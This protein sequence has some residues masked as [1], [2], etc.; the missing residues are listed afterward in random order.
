M[1][2]ELATWD[3]ERQG[4]TFNIKVGDTIGGTDVVQ[5]QADDHVRIEVHGTVNRRVIGYVASFNGTPLVLQRPHYVAVF[6]SPP[7]VEPRKIRRVLYHD[8]KIR[9]LVFGEPV[10]PDYLLVLRKR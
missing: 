2:N 1:W 9:L 6:Y 3:I 4:L 7:T 8:A 5:V 10:V